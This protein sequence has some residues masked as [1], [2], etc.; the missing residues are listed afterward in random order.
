MHGGWQLF[1]PT[2]LVEMEGRLLIWWVTLY[3]LTSVWRRGERE[4]HTRAPTRLASPGGAGC[5]VARR[6]ARAHDVRVYSLPKS[7]PKPRRPTASFCCLF[8]YKSVSNTF[9]RDRA[10]RLRDA[11]TL[12][13]SSLYI[14]VATTE[15]GIDQQPQKHQH[16]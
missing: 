6:W 7:G 4:K 15:I 13:R 2:L 8:C 5:G 10:S 16:I 9:D 11:V 3:V 14:C 1:S 12:G